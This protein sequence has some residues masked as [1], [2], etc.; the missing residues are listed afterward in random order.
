MLCTK[1]REDAILSLLL[2]LKM[3]E[4]E[5]MNSISL[6]NGKIV[7]ANGNEEGKRLLGTAQGIANA[8][9][10]P[11]NELQTLSML[12]KVLEKVQY[13]KRKCELVLAGLTEFKGNLDLVEQSLQGSKDLIFQRTASCTEKAFRSVATSLATAYGYVSSKLRSYCSRPHQN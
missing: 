12:T 10:I 9:I 11:G 1:V 2:N 7:L 6:D 5:Y 8:L 3:S 4:D 13:E